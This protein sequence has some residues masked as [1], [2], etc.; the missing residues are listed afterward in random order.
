MR[1]PFLPALLLAVI[2]I[3]VDLY[4]YKVCRRRF[5]SRKPSQICLWSS[6]VLYALLILAIALPRRSGDNGTLLCVMWMLFSLMSVYVSKIVFVIFD[7]IGRIPQ[8][9]KSRRLRF[10][11]L[12]GIGASVVTFLAMWWGALIN[13]FDIDVREVEIPVKG[14]PDSFDGYRI[15][16]ISDFHTGTYGNDTTF[17]SKVVNT[18]NGLDADLVVFTG[19][20]VNSRSKEIDPHVAPLSKLNGRDGV[21]AVLG[22][23][24]YGDYA[25]WPTPEAKEE[26]RRHLRDAIRRMG[27][28][29]LDNSTAILREGADSLALIGVENIGDPPFH[30]YGSLDMAYPDLSDG[31]TKILLSHNPAH[32]T[33]SIENDPSK[34]IALTLAGHTHAMQMEVGGWSPAVFRYPTWGGLYAS[35]DSVRHLYVNIGLGEVGFPARIGATPEVTVLTLRKSD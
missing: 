17:V 5:A 3:L 6:L 19:D 9:W 33:D 4:I 1:I 24:D 31:V 15:V 16:Q 28:T 34:N 18:I 20:I 23:H 27:W 25:V 26:S 11:S 12:I 14:L 35:P 2:F 13:R 7:L 8:L 22:N 21:Y 32:W 29:L 30:I 10:V